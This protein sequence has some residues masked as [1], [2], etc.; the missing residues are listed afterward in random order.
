MPSFQPWISWE[1]YG[2][3]RGNDTVDSAV[4]V[5]AVWRAD[6]DAD[7]FRDPVTRL[8]Y[9]QVI[10]PTISVSV[11]NVGEDFLFQTVGEL[12]ELVVPVDPGPVPLLI[13]GTCF[14]MIAGNGFAV[15]TYHWP[16]R[17]PDAWLALH[18]W[19]SRWIARVRRPSS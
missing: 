16:E 8:R 11:N 5:E 13:D 18:D 9:P 12:R 6:I 15:V 1:L 7:K 2:Q 17:P 4:L 14:E 10:E 3:K 19:A